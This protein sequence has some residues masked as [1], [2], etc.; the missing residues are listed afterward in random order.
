MLA[1]GW[2]RVKVARLW[3][4]VCAASIVA[5]MIGYGIGDV[6]DRAT[7]AFADTFAAGALLVMLTNSMIPEA[8][9]Q[10]KKE[11]GLLFA[12]GFAVALALTVA[13]L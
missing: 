3:F 7:G 6:F 9:E 10:G 8:F 11:A 1:A 12:F 4:G 5:A 2:S 13:Q